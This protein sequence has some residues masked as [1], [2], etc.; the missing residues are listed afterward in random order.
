MHSLPLCVRLNGRPVIL[1]GEGEAA[2]AKARLLR[3]AGAQIV[4]EEAEAALAI[5]ALADNAAALAAIAR[6][7]ESCL[8]VNAVATPDQSA[9]HLP[10]VVDSEPEDGRGSG[11]G[12]GGESVE[13][14]GVSE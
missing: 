13:V 3:R 10:D 4:G 5:V 1:V 8:L 11:G 14:C 7:K 2:E 12:S 6:L 9:F